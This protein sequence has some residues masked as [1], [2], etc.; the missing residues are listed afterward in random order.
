MNILHFW[1]SDSGAFGGGGTISMLRLHESLREAGINSNILCQIKTSKS[2]HVQVLQRHLGTKIVEKLLWQLTSRAGLNDVH[3]VSSFNIKN[4]QSYREASVVHFHGTHSGFINYL[5]L[6]ALTKKPAVFTLKDMWAMTG[7]CSYS[8]ECD[9]WQSGCGH[10]P[11]LGTHPAVK[12]DSTRLEWK[13]KDWIYRQMKLVLICPSQWI[14][15]K[16]KQS[17]LTKQF[18]IYHIPHAVDLHTLQPLD[19]KHCRLQLG[20]PLDKNVLMFSAVDLDDYRKGGDLL[21]KA[22]QNL[23][24]SLKDKTVLLIIGKKARSL[25]QIVQLPVYHLGYLDNEHKKAMAYSA[26][27]LTLFPTRADIFGLVSIESQACGTPVVSFEVG[28][29]PE[30]VR[31]GITGYLAQPE[32]VVDFS[33]G[34]TQ[35]L[36]NEPLRL[37]MS[38][39]CRQIAIQEYNLEKYAFRH[40]ELYKQ[41]LE[42]FSREHR[43]PQSHKIASNKALHSFR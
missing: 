1:K 42:N 10:C 22:L 5:A 20:L 4:Y 23:S 21:L 29:V 12:R 24:K 2:P 35:L 6:P 31:S 3:R 17:P 16:A 19:L 32:N 25:T 26:A 36:E 41:L 9:R 13:L 28:G 37:A 27:D 30:H 43:M 39:R 34:I 8:F 11:A 7:H 14:A 18:P 38:Q 15:E 33:T 40:I